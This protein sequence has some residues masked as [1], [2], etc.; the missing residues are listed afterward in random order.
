MPPKAKKRRGFAPACI[1]ESL[2]GPWLIQEGKLVNSCNIIKAVR[3]KLLE[4]CNKSET[5]DTHKD[6]IERY[7][8][9][10][11]DKI[12]ELYPELISEKKS[13]DHGYSKAFSFTTP[14]SERHITLLSPDFSNTSDKERAMLAYELGKFEY[15]NIYLAL[16][17]QSPDKSQLVENLDINALLRSQNAT[18]LGF[19]SGISNNTFNSSVGKDLQESGQLLQDVTTKPKDMYRLYKTVE[20]VLQLINPHVTLPLHLQESLVLY[21]STGSKIALQITSMGS[22]HA[23][24]QM[25]KRLLDTLGSVENTTP[26]GDIVAAFDNNQVLNRPWKVRLGA[27]YVVNIVTMVVL[28]SINKEGALQHEKSLIPSSWNNRKLN[29]VE[30]DKIKKV[31]Q[32]DEIHRKHLQ[33][34]LAQS[35]KTVISEQKWENGKWK[36]HIDLKV[37]ERKKAKEYKKCL[38]CGFDQVPKTKHNCIQCKKNLKESERKAI[39]IDDKGTFTEKP[40]KK[41][42]QHEDRVTVVKSQSGQTT[43]KTS[44]HVSDP[45]AEYI[46][47]E[48]KNTDNVV[49][50]H[51]QRPIFQNPCSYDAVDRVL[52]GVGKRGRVRKYL[53]PEE[54]SSE[55]QDIREWL[56]VYCDGV[57]LVLANRLMKCCYRCRDCNERLLGTDMCSEHELETSHHNYE[58]EFDWLHL[59]AGGGHVEMNMLKGLVELLWD[60]FWG[61]MVKLYN[62]VS[63]AAQKAAKKVSDYHKGW[64][65]ARI[66]RQAIALELMTPFVRLMMSNDQTETTISPAHFTK[67]LMTKV[68]DKTF[69][70]ISDVMF[71][72]IDSLF[73]YRCGVR[74]G[75]K[76]MM[77][78]ARGKFAKLWSG[79]PHPMYRELEMSDLLQEIRM[80]SELHDFISA[81]A[82][83]NTTGRPY[84]G[85][86]PDFRCEESNKDVQNILPHTPNGKDWNTACGGRDKVI[87]VRE[88]LFKAS[89]KQDPK[90]GSKAPQANID[91][92]VNE[93]RVLLREKEYLLHP[94]KENDL[95][96]LSGEP[97]DQGLLNFCSKA[98][99]LRNK[100]VDVYLEYEQTASKSKPQRPKFCEKPI[101]ITPRER[102]QH[103][104]ISPQSP[105]AIKKIV[106]SKLTEIR[107]DDIRETYQSVW[108]G[109]ILKMNNRKPDKDILLEFYYEVIN[110]VD[111]EEVTQSDDIPAA[112]E[113]DV[114]N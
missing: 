86:G 60:V 25:V 67:F 79:R 55:N 15:S 69:L 9:N 34:F 108:K 105:A 5:V 111:Q 13:D 89:D 36:D 23:S 2:H 33:P 96:S 80:P 21:T 95:R 82:S 17:Q 94:L 75:D 106:E 52:Q 85:Q 44:R 10:C 20:S 100:Y 87:K 30:V 102:A 70:F 99:E 110:V 72:L 43:L 112:P 93:F 35:L 88:Q 3:D 12:A 103:E 91:E 109:D 114:S 113:D 18:L 64:T 92:E 26:N 47:F 84:C 1:S 24:Y 39:G 19:L 104:E 56:C 49:E 78:A 61:E 101:F 38:A 58:T 7:C 8:Q 57:P 90:I 28:F 77:D 76:G 68:K 46:K 73:M 59:K 4:L 41:Y 31:D 50:S 6:R 98:R 48:C 65:L 16:S 62:F 22:P 11:I 107:N 63:E 81:S 14:Q 71:E 83:L 29:A 45:E 27:K 51:L 53:T 32:C 40:G 66:V 42:R 37:E 54:L 97:L 74:C